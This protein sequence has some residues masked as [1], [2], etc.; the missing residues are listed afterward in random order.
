MQ[1]NQASHY[2]IYVDKNG[3]ASFDSGEMLTSGFG[4]SILYSFNL[5]ND[6]VTDSLFKLRL[7][8]DDNNILND[9]CTAPQG[10]TVF[11]FLAY[12]VDETTAPIVNWSYSNLNCSFN[13]QFQNNSILA[14]N[15][16][17][18]FGDGNSSNLSNPLHTYAQP[19]NYTVLLTATNSEGTASYSQEIE[20]VASIAPVLEIS[21]L[22]IAENALQFSVSEVFDNYFWEFSTGQTSFDPSPVAVFPDSGFYQVSALVGSGSC[23]YSIDSTFR[24]DYISNTTSANFDFI[25]PD[26]GQSISFLNLSVN[27]INYTWNFGDGTTSTLLN[28]SHTFPNEGVYTVSLTANGLSN[29]DTDV[30]NIG[31]VNFDD[32]LNVSSNSNQGTYTF[33][34]ENSYSSYFWTIN[35]VAEG[36]TSSLTRN[37]NISGFYVIEVEVEKFGCTKTINT[38]LSIVTSIDNPSEPFSAVKLYPNPTLNQSVLEW[39]TSSLPSDEMEVA[40]LDLTGRLIQQSTIE[41]IGANSFR[42]V[43]YPGDAAGVYLVRLSAGNIQKFMKL[44]KE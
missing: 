18:N 24:V 3:N 8:L 30:V 9:P 34:L 39:S 23:F 36:T 43:V 27:A 40:I 37:F 29:A 15:Y 26:C 35:G 17:W 33:N 7:L 11:D 38:T 31:V 12:I 44:M 42:A 21:G 28:P 6:A 16:A 13:Y 4:S 14:D 19:G 2:A 22:A 10:G 20:V 41:K 25:Q 1:F 5:G 32:V